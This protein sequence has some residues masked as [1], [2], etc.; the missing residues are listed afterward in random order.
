MVEGDSKLVMHAAQG[1]CEISWNFIFIVDDIRLLVSN[2]TDV[3]WMHIF[4]EA[5]FVTDAFSDQGLHVQNDHFWEFC[6]PFFARATFDLDNIG[7]GC[8]HGFSL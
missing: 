1:L 8:T 5:N 7:I 3:Q 4:R 2:F 6:V